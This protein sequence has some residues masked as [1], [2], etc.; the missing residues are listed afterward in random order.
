MQKELYT[1]VQAVHDT[2]TKDTATYTLS[3]PNQQ[4]VDA[5]VQFIKENY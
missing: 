2:F 3:K 1:L 4:A 5:L